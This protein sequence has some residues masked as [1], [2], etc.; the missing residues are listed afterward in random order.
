[1][2]MDFVELNGSHSGVNIEKAFSESLMDFNVFDKKL[3]ITLDN[4]YNNEQ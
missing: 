2:L 1:M 4:A 3:A